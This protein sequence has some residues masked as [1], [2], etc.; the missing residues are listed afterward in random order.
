[1]WQVRVS[2]LHE[3]SPLVKR[4]ANLA[5]MKTALA[6]VWLVVLTAAPAARAADPNGYAPTGSV[7]SNGNVTTF[8]DDRVVSP[9]ANLSRRPDGSWAGELAGR[10]IDVAVT[11]DG[12]RGVEVNLSI[13]AEKDETQVAG[14]VFGRPFRLDLRKDRIDVRY[15]RVVQQHTRQKDGTWHP[16]SMQTPYALELK[17]QAAA[18]SPPLPQLVLSFIANVSRPQAR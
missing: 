10:P 6:A 5:R 18:P 17:G 1:V 9:V 13:T 12:I 14:L 8:S 7:A 2:G 3:Q 16:L 4:P 11:A 15:D